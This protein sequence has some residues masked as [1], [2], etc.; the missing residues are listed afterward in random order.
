MSH[1]S[2]YPKI[3][4]LSQKLCS[5]ARLRTDTDTQTYT[6]VTTE[7]TFSGFQE[8]FLQPISKDRPNTK[9]KRKKKK[10]EKK[11]RK[12]TSNQTNRRTNNKQTC[13]HTVIKA[14]TDRQHDV[15][16]RLSWQT[17]R[18]ASKADM[19]LGMQWRS[20]FIQLHALTAQLGKP[21]VL[22]LDGERLVMHGG[23]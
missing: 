14:H 8:F 11:N 19:Q 10:A 1:G 13:T 16:D 21:C 2:F 15:H 22:S 5:V 23:Q 12:K 4:F 3:R 17:A 18:H 9:K 6:K 7:G 20:N